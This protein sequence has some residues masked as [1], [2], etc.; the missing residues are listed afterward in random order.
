MPLYLDHLSIFDLFGADILLEAALPYKK[1][2][3]KFSK[4]VIYILDNRKLVMQ[5]TIT[6]KLETYSEPCQTSMIGLFKK[7]V[8][9][10]KP[11]IIF[12]KC[13]NLDV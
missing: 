13:S 12:T 8:N 3:G 7:I 11:K 10:C 2:K 6:T 1:S 5:G 4:S 9:E